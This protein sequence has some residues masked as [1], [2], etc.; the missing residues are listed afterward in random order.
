MTS[1]EYLREEARLCP[2]EAEFDDFQARLAAL[3]HDVERAEARLQNLVD[4]LQPR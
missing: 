1:S 2:T 4:K 3:R